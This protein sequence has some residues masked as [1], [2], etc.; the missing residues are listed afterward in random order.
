VKL[1]GLTTGVGS[2]P[3]ADA[4]SSS[5]LITDLWPYLPHLAELPERGPWAMMTGRAAGFLTDLHMDLTTTGW[6]IV[7]RPGSDHRRASTL[8]RDDIDRFEE[9]LEGYVGPIKS[10][11]VGPWT[12][13]ASLE[14]QRGRPLLKDAAACRDIAHSIAEGIGEHIDR[15]RRIAG[16]TEILIQ[17]DEPS[18][19]AIS[20]GAGATLFSHPRVPE[21]FE[22]RTLL[23]HVADEIK[24]Y[25][26]RSI[27]HS[28]AVPIRWDLIGSF[29]A[30]SVD[31][32]LPH[33]RE[34]LAAWSEAG[35]SLWLGWPPPPTSEPFPD[36]SATVAS[37]IA[38]LLEVGLPRESLHERISVTP[39]C[40]LAHVDPDSLVAVAGRIRDV[41][42]SIQDLA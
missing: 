5:K 30:A 37:V 17:V 11:V 14:S 2:M 8:L 24:R 32:S 15:L 21:E 6:R 39:A 38:P 27:L 26:A 25:G 23:S 29:E 22:L 13:L 34:E 18:L 20:T 7:D 42:S 35:R 28:C 41:I 36:L 33:R 12:L 16:V 40:G 3:G 10:Q 19:T 4:R 1:S 31:I 9:A